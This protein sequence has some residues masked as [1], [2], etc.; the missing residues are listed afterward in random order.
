MLPILMKLET[1]LSNEFE[2]LDINGLKCFL[3]P[4]GEVVNLVLFNNCKAVAGQYA[5]S[6]E[7]A[8]KNLFEDGRRFFIEEMTEEEIL[9]ALLQEMKDYE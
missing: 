5:Q 6:I 8:Q 1:R 9:C 3:L 4:S 2:E 7:D